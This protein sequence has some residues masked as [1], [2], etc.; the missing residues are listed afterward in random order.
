MHDKA[1]MSALLSS[2]P[3]LEPAKTDQISALPL[4]G[5]VLVDPWTDCIELVKTPPLSLVSAREKLPLEV[6]PFF[7]D[8]KYAK[9]NQSSRASTSSP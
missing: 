3:Q 4:G 7:P 1:R 8:L 6:T 9:D 2:A 5:R